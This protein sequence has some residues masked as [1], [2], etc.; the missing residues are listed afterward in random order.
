MDF[1]NKYDWWTEN[2]K[3]IVFSDES[4]FYVEDFRIR[5]VRRYPGEELPQEFSNK[6]VKAKNFKKIMIWGAISYQ[7]DRVMKFIEGSLDSSKYLKILTK[8]IPLIKKFMKG[9]NWKFQ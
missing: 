9:K 2:W 6:F 7:G 3:N 1:A 5:Y 8:N 4:W